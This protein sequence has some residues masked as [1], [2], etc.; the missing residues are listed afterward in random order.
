LDGIKDSIGRSTDEARI[1]IPRYTQ[2]ANEYHE[3]AIESAS[4]IAE[5]FPESQ[6]RDY[7]FFAIGMA[8]SNRGSKSN[9]IRLDVSTKFHTSI[10][11][12]G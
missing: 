8:T 1:D 5:N 2:A 3:Q 12:Y 10:C 4:E 6:K 7:Q 11:K 9:Y